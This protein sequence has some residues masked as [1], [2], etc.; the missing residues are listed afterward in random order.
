MAHFHGWPKCALLAASSR[1]CGPEH[2]LWLLCVTWTVHT[3]PAWFWKEPPKSRHLK[4]PG[5][6]CQTCYGSLFHCILCEASQW[7]QAR[8]KRNEIRLCLWVRIAAKNHSTTG[9]WFSKQQEHLCCP[10]PWEGFRTSPM[11]SRRSVADSGI[12]SSVPECWWPQKLTE[13]A[14]TRLTLGFYEMKLKVLEKGG[15]SGNRLLSIFP[16]GLLGLSHSD[17]ASLHT[18][19]DSFGPF[20]HGV[21]FFKNFL[22]VFVSYLASLQYDLSAFLYPPA[23]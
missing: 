5:R 6:R 11:S 2:L 16:L 13:V 19:F 15:S 3:L 8:L 14:I 22:Y 7:G 4:S 9:G 1:D 21:D 20:L 23:N 18:S 17:F 12:H 10:P